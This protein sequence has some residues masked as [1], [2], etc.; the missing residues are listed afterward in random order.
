MIP[1]GNRTAHNNEVCGTKERQT[2]DPKRQ[3]AKK[4]NYEITKLLCLRRKQSREEFLAQYSP[5]F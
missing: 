4:G 2:P 1:V 3:T 5:T